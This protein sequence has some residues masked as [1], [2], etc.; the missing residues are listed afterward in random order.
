MELL[1]PVAVAEGQVC[2]LVCTGPHT[3]VCV[4]VCRYERE[5]RKLRAELQKR[6]KSLVDKRALLEVR[7]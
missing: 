6:S 2:Q 4:C 1:L 3:H 7:V 5:L